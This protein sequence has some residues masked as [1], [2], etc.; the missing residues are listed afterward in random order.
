MLS[1]KFRPIIK[2]K[3]V[4]KTSSDNYRPIINSTNIFKLFECCLFP[5]YSHFLKINSCQF[6]YQN[7]TSCQSAV[8]ILKETVMSYI[9]LNSDVHCTALDLPKA[10]HRLNIAVLVEI[11][12]TA[13]VF[14]QYY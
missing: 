12:R 13:W 5:I 7:H 2:I 14:G 1:D 3:A 10:F 4:N 9:K 8:V 6:G 11:P